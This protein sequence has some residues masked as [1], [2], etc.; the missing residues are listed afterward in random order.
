MDTSITGEPAAPEHVGV[1][2]RAITAAI[3]VGGG[4]TATA[5]YVVRG[6]Q[7]GSPAPAAPVTTGLVPNLILTGW[8]GGAALAALC[9]W[10][11]MRPIQSSYRRGA[12]AMVAAFAALVLALVTMPADALFG[13]GGLLSISLVGLAGGLLLARRAWRRME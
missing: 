6:L 8:L 13:R 7:A 4:V 3:F 10:L 12:F 9:A 2:L 11:L 5:L 1:A